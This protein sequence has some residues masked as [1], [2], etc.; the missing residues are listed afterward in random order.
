MGYQPTHQPT[1]PSW[2]KQWLPPKD[3]H[4]ATPSVLVKAGA[5]WAMSTLWIQVWFLFLGVYAN[6]NKIRP[7]LSKL[8]FGVVSAEVVG[9]ACTWKKHP[10]NFSFTL[11]LD[12]CTKFH[13]K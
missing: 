8:A 11:T 9:L 5:Q 1:Q 13:Q 3:I 10:K 7:I 12:L 2:L 6:F 4:L